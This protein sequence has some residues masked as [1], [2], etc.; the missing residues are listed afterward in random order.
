M[1]NSEK[2][3]RLANSL[4][5]TFR[6]TNELDNVAKYTKVIAELLPN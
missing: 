3:I 1:D 6:R 2:S 5:K 4:A